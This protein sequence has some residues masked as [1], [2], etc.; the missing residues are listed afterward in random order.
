MSGDKKHKAIEAIDNLHSL[1]YNEVDEEIER[2]S[3]FDD[4]SGVFFEIMLD[5]EQPNDIRGNAAYI[6]TKMYLD[7][8]RSMHSQV[9]RLSFLMLKHAV[10][11]CP[12]LVKTGV[13]DSFLDNHK[14]DYGVLMLLY[15]LFEDD[16][17]D[18]AILAAIKEVEEDV[19]VEIENNY[20]VKERT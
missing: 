10:R 3:V 1:G 15:R 18:E 11:A 8:V 14:G 4:E 7:I 2:L 12:Y 5:P 6:W 19:S 17:E 16:M 9:T 13:I 20:T